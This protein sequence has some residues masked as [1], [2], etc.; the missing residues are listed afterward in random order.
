MIKRKV[1]LVSESLSDIILE[2]KIGD[3]I[4]DKWM[5]IDII[6]TDDNLGDILD[7]DIDNSQMELGTHYEKYIE[8]IVYGVDDNKFYLLDPSYEVSVG[9]CDSLDELYDICG[10]E[11]EE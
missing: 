2:S 1:Y 5:I 6:D 10:F 11:D 3:L 4:E 7:N 9:P 8:Y